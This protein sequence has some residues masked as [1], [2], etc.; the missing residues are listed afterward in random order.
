MLMHHQLPIFLA[1]SLALTAVAAGA[2]SP[3]REAPVVAPGA[4]VRLMLSADEARRTGRGLI[5][6]SLLSGDSVRVLIMRKDGTR[7][8]TIPTFTIDDVELYTGQRRRRTMI[9]GG[10]AAG[11]AASG[12]IYA[13]DRFSR[14][15]RCKPEKDCPLLPSGYYAI[16]IGVGA[17]FGATF[18]ASHWVRVPRSAVNVG[19]TGTHSIELS[20][21]IGFR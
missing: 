21:S 13:V 19:L 4:R 6:G 18:S 20:G 9:V 16:P 3:R 17:I 1:A 5:S 7:V 11:A 14:A 10:S 8:D 15:H 12:L 2:Q